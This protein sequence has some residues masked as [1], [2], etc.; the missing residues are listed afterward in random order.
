MKLWNKIIVAPEGRHHLLDGEPLYAERY[1]A[2]LTFHSPGLAPVRLGSEAWHIG[3]DGRP[4]YRA[5]FHETFGFYEGLAAVDSDDGWQHILPDGR[6]LSPARFAWCGN[7]QNG[8]CAVRERSGRYLHIDAKGRPI[9]TERW[10]YAGDF[11]DGAAVVQADDG[12]ST[13]IDRAGRMVHGRWFWDLDVFHKG[14][15]R[16]Q[17]DR[18]WTHVDQL[19]R[20]L[21]SRRFAMVEP[22]YNGQAR[23]E[24]FDGGLEVIDHAGTT[25]VELRPARRSEFHAIS[26]DIVGFWR[27]WTLCAAA[28]LG[29]LDHLP[30]ATAAVA[31]A[32]GLEPAAA[33]RLLDALGELQMV[34]REGDGWRA[35]A[36]GVYLRH[37]HPSTLRDAAVEFPRKFT[38]GWSHLSES[39]RGARSGA[40]RFAEVSEDP[41]RCQRF[42]RMLRSYA[43]EDYIGRRL[44]ELL[45]LSEITELI[46]AGGGLGVI[47]E[48]LLASSPGLR[49]T[50]LD[51]PEVLEHVRVAEGLGAR[52]NLCPGDLFE[53]WGLRGDA[54]LLARVLHDWDDERCHV[55][56]RHARA[57]LEPGRGRLF[58]IE[59]IRSDDGF[60]G[61]LCDL[62]LLTD[63]GGAERSRAQLEALLDEA[64]FEVIA[65]K[66]FGSVPSILIAAAR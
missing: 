65:Q 24:R 47:A 56:L 63:T 42:H 8:R 54:V 14:H 37:D 60:D 18:G 44:A 38:E 6:E 12:R 45:D 48:E 30:A 23:V 1:D 50:L 53:P 57:A 33:R 3:A 32:T 52:L 41:E 7:F 35:T 20:P 59:M 49:V 15:A 22:F 66:S 31:A 19:G 39:L 40:D 43:R 10:R 17:D 13:H 26:A 25:V 36:R 29:V 61:A 4:A 28:E 16:A 27:S 34:E 58:V 62:H 9:S 64:G 55:I 5:R 46:D 11:R 51:R 2:V 21:S